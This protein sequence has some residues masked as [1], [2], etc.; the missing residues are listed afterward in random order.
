MPFDGP[1]VFV[2]GSG[3]SA[4]MKLPT[5]LN[6]FHTLMDH[7]EREGEEDKEQILNALEV[8]YPHFRKVKSAPS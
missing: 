5:L 4:S 1:K 3:F 7:P 8:L 2:L 6:L